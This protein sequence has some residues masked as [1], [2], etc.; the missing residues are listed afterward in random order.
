M[1][2]FL[3]LARTSSALL[4]STPPWQWRSTRLRATPPAGFN[5]NNLPIVRIENHFDNVMQNDNV[6]LFVNFQ[7]YLGSLPVGK[8]GVTGMY[9]RL[10][11]FPYW[12]NSEDMA[13]MVEQLETENPFYRGLIKYLCSPSA[14]GTTSSVLVAF[15]ES[16]EKS[17]D[18]FKY[19]FYLPCASNGDRNYIFDVSK[20]SQGSQRA[21]DQG[22]AFAFECIQHLLNNSTGHF[23]EVDENVT[24]HA[25]TVDEMSEY[26][27]SR[28][29]EGRILIHVDE[30][31]KMCDDKKQPKQSAAFRKGA[32]RALEK[33]P[34]VTVIATGEKPLVEVDPRGSPTICR[35]PVMLPSVDISQVMNG[36]SDL[37]FT[38]VYDP[39]TFTAV[40]KRLWATLNF[41]LGLRLASRSES[42]VVSMMDIHLHS[43][44]LGT[45]P[46][47]GRSNNFIKEFHSKF[48]HAQS[49]T[50]ALEACID[51]CKFP[52]FKGNGQINDA[53][54]LLLGSDEE[55]RLNTL[56]LRSSDIALYSCG[57]M[58]MGLTS[59]LE[60]LLSASDKDFIVYRN[61]RDRFRNILRSS[62][63]LDLLP[64]TP[65]EAAYAWTLSCKSA[66]FG[67][68]SFSRSATF[69]IRCDRLLG[70]RYFLGGNTAAFDA[71]SLKNNKMYYREKTGIDTDP[72]FDIFFRTEKNEIVFIDVYGGRSQ[73]EAEETRNRLS[74]WIGDNKKCGCT[75]HGVLLAPFVSGYTNTEGTVTLVQGIGA[76]QLLGGFMQA[77]RWLRA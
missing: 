14:S 20:L 61:G 27:R 63:S 77:A 57:P 59:S 25:K 7:T 21:Y 51:L 6:P 73:E 72:P 11:Q 29:L 30:H 33:M 31:R 26:V 16:A 8:D 36:V 68:L 75:F 40:E 76:Q 23:S 64:A 60:M 66:L 19:Y 4:H 46:H 17:E 48:A 10:C 50:E 67:G 5:N 44:S 70:S 34:Y 69:R 41:L 55:R 28:G 38:S 18:G 74:F 65:L 58:Y 15:L 62:T 53:V 1:R 24:G 22:G 32:M 13:L 52:S 71:M 9:E 37:N 35:F 56:D 12:A 2:V 49:A 42:G 47:G 45:P 43:G 3:F 54:E 39:A